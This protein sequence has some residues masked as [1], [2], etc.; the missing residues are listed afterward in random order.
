MNFQTPRRSQGLLM[1]RSTFNPAYR[2]RSLP[3]RA[4]SSVP[5]RDPTTARRRSDRSLPPG[6]TDISS[7]PS[8]SRPSRYREPVPSRRS[9]FERGLRPLPYGRCDRS[10]LAALF[11]S[12]S[13]SPACVRQAPSARSRQASARFRR[14]H[15]CSASRSPLPALTTCSTVPID[16]LPHAAVPVASST[17]CARPRPDRRRALRDAQRR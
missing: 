5:V 3:R 13:C 2:H 15:A 1:A 7:K 8:A 9:T 4:R 17:C 6:G 12:P 11:L 14:Q 10:P 16:R